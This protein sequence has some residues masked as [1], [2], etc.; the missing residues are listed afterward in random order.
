VFDEQAGGVPAARD[1]QA[2]ARRVGMGLDG[3]FADLED[4]SDFLGLEM[5]GDQPQD[6]L[7][8][9][10]QCVH[11]DRLVPQLPLPLY[12]MLTVEPGNH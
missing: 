5:L 6:L 4:T 10:G 3:A 11:R 1:A 12:A 7:L 9:L 2:P 8:A